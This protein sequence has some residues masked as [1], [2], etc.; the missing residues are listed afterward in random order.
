MTSSGMRIFTPN[1]PGVGIMRLR[2]PVFPVHQEGNSIWKNLQALQ[3]V[4]LNSGTWDHIL[5][6]KLVTHLQTHN[7]L[8][9]SGVLLCSY[10][11]CFWS[12][13]IKDCL[14]FTIELRS[15]ARGRRRCGIFYYHL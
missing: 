6:R 13:V 8:T 4:S 5:E 15:C 3:D 10:I 11:A 2:Y 9:L 7:K 14:H 12:S 1:I